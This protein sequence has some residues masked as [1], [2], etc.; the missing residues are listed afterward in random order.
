MKRLRDGGEG[1]KKLFFFFSSTQDQLDENNLQQTLV[2]DSFF[3]GGKP[4]SIV[5][6]RKKIKFMIQ[7]S[8]NQD[9]H[10]S[11]WIQ[12]IEQRFVI[13]RE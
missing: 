10:G 12:K 11:K 2:N 6:Q 8:L 13:L 5:T 7:A 4:S 9:V 1:S 3:L